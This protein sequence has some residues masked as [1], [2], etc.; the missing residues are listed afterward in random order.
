[1]ALSGT[2]AVAVAGDFDPS[3]NTLGFTRDFIPDLSLRL[4]REF[5]G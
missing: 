4:Y 1:M 5:G 3:F 2:A